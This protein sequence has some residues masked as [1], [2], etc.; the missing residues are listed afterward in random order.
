MN[1][2]TEIHDLIRSKI[3]IDYPNFEQAPSAVREKFEALPTK[4]NFFRMLGHSVGAFIPVVDLTNAVFR[5]L[6]I[7]DYHKELIV[8]LVATVE[9]CAYEWEQH[10]SIGQAAGVRPK[11]FIAIAEGHLDDSSSFEEDERTLLLFAKSILERGKASGVLFKH[12]LRH[13][14]VEVLSDAVL[15]TG[16][17]RMVSNYLRTF[18]I[19]I[20]AQSDGTWIKG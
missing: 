3:Q 18:D 9:D 20:D 5:D 7:S 2:T 11:Q 13:F 8:L 15:V 6:T 16:Y 17:Y 10:V 1:N 19:E 4:V 14:P 12:A